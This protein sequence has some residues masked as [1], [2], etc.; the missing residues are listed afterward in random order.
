MRAVDAWAIKQAGRAVAR[1]D[2]ASRRGLG[3]RRG[4]GGAA[5]TGAGRGGGRGN[6][7]G[8]GLV[9]ARLLRADGTRSTCS[10]PG[11]LG[12]PARR[13][14]RQPG[15]AAGRAR[16]SG[17]ARGARRAPAGRRRAAR[18]RLRGR[19]ARAGSGRDRR[20]Q[21]AGRAGRRLRRALGVNA[22]HRRGQGRRSTRGRDRDLPRARSR[23]LRGPGRGHAGAVEAIEIGMPRGAPGRRAGR[24]DLRARARPLPAPRAS[25]SKFASGMVVV[26]GGSGGLTGAPRWPRASARAPAPAT[27]RWRCPGPAQPASSCDCWS[28]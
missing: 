4:S 21:R 12:R 20:D 25:G 19:S 7:G 6:N 28:R 15:A 24:A 17:R 14:A 18:N 5:G 3:A 11:S 10:R 13:R 9:L 27:C 23:A 26:A 8:D 16:P 22:S 2:G 1:A